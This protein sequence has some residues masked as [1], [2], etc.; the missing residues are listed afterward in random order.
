V[1]PSIQVNDAA[2]ALA[3]ASELGYPLALKSTQPGLL[4]K[5]E[6]GGVRLHLQDEGQLLEAYNEM[7]RRLGPSALVCR[8]AGPGVEML[9]GVVRDEQ[10]GP[11][12]LL[13]FGGIL[14][15]S[16]RDVACALPPFTP[17]TARRLVDGLRQRSLL[18]G[19]RGT[20]PVDIDSF[21]A[22]AASVSVLAARLGD[23]VAEI[24]INPV[25]V[26]ADGCLALDALVA[27]R[28]PVDNNGF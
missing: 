8:M 13:G 28:K 14:V 5:T 9:L 17:A 15:E 27:G 20:P 2:T 26:R 11:L 24:D 19:H 18:D 23:V 12:V 16:M 3:A 7:S 6:K 10:F 1:N 25:L 4:H 21:C 22:A